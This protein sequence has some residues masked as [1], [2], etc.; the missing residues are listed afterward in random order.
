MQIILLTLL[1]LF[2]SQFTY[3]QVNNISGIKFNSQNVERSQ[4]TSLFLYE[5]NFIELDGSFSISFDISFWDYKEFGPILRIQ[6]NAGN[7]FRI[8]YSPFKDRDT[9][10][11]ELIEPSDKNQI[12]LK[13]PKKNLIRNNWF[14]LKL[15]FD[16]IRKKI[17]AYYNNS[18]VSSIDY[19]GLKENNYR[20]A[21]GIKDFN[22]PNDFDVP[23]ISVKN[24][25]IS[26][27]K[28]VKYFWELNP[29]E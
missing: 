6:D 19:K 28:E 13:L 26:E 18:W 16:K 14:N 12:T 4:K 8:V 2:F 27:D 3:P 23:A 29:L 11:I 7:E 5:N 15:T 10:V 25:I 21:F 24:I 22:N 20:F 9:S 17:K 1:I